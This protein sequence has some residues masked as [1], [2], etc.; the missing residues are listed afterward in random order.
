LRGVKIKGARRKAAGAQIAA[1]PSTNDILPPRSAVV[2][3]PVSKPDKK[4]REAWL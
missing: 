1:G 2:A 3:G 4:P